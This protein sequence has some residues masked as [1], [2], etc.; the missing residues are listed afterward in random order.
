M[1]ALQNDPHIAIRLLTHVAA[2]RVR[3]KALPLSAPF[4]MPPLT[5]G[6][7]IESD[8]VSERCDTSAAATKGDRPRKAEVGRDGDG[9]GGIEKVEDDCRELAC[10]FQADTS[11]TQRCVI[12]K[13]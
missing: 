5:L 7:P 2:V 4:A 6:V 9:D 11:D 12:L 3:G 8:R 13:R 10:L 1:T